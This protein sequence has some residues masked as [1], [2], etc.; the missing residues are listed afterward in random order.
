[1]V[2]AVKWARAI[3][4]ALLLSL[5]AVQGARAEPRVANDQVI[6][7]GK[8]SICADV[9]AEPQEFYD[10]KGELVGSDIDTGNAIAGRL[11]LTP[12]WVKTVFDTM[13]VALKSGKCDL[14]ISGMFI[15][16]AR[17]EQIEMIPYLNAGQSYVVRAG[18]A[19]TLGDPVADPNVMCGHPVVVVNGTGEH[20]T[21]QAESAKC[22]RAGKKPIEIVLGKL[23][24]DSLMQLSTRH[25]DFFG[26]DTPIAQYFGSTHAKQFEVDGGSFAPILEGIGV[27]KDRKPLHDAVLGALK[28]M[29]S[30][31][32]YTKILNK[33]GL[34]PKV[35]PAN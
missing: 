35:P 7:P 20:E 32:T 25:A 9:P 19:K 10:D 30:D 22:E 18:E 14:I 16:P 33:W 34:D 11:G 28:A 26:I 8:L 17:L 13:I 2:P 4:G 21:V 3:T 1:M 29:E 12:S 15:R 5:G 31:G 27:R 23:V 24:S 6:V